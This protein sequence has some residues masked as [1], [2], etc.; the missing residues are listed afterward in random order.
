MLLKAW[1]NGDQAALDRL[2]P[3]VYAELHRMARRH[4]G[5]ERENTLQTT[6]LVNEAYLRLVDA[7]GI[8]CKDRTHFFA[9][10]AQIMR[11]ILVDAA[12]ARV[13]VKRGGDALPLDHSEA[14]NLVEIAGSA[15]KRAPRFWRWIER[16]TTSHAWT[17]EKRASSNC[18]FLVA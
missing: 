8:A 2:T 13:S 16:W 10:S 12:R 3:L 18:A 17:H 15:H 6:A 7:K 5:K 11:R 14:I 1:G 4:M 9:L